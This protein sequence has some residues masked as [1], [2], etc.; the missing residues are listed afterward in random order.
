V[1]GCSFDTD[2]DRQQQQRC[3]GGMRVI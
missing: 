1:C 3:I 2:G